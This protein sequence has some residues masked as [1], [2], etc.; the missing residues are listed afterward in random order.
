[1]DNISLVVGLLLQGA[2]NPLDCRAVIRQL[3]PYCYFFSCYSLVPDQHASSQQLAFTAANPISKNNKR[4]LAQ[5]YYIE[6]IKRDF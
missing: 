5:F 1:M 2:V 6:I 4:S 3:S